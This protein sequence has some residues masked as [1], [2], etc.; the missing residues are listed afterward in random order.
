MKDMTWLASL[1]KDI[2][3]PEN[4]ELDLFESAGD[5]CSYRTLFI[6]INGRRYSVVG[7]FELE[8]E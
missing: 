7:K 2:L 8:Q 1:E 5:A 6:N 3:A 4:V